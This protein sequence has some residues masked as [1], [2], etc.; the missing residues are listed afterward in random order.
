MNAI[1]IIR[2]WKGLAGRGVW[3]RSRLSGAVSGRREKQRVKRG[4]KRETQR[5]EIIARYVCEHARLLSKSNVTSAS[6]TS[7]PPPPPTPA[8]FFAVAPANPY[9]RREYRSNVALR[10]RRNG[11]WRNYFSPPL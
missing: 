4:L 3:R 6:R 10:F 5:E 1:Y 8:S 2:R 7:P 11:G 9:D